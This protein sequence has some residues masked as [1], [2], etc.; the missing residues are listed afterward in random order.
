MLKDCISDLSDG[1]GSIAID[2]ERASGYKYSARAYLLQVTRDQK[3]IYLID[4]ISIDDLKLWQRFNETFIETEWIIHASTQDLPCLKELGLFPKKLF[5]TELG[6]RL[7]GFPKVAL[8]SLV[9]TMLEFEL[10]KEHSAVDWS[11]RPLKE[12]WLTYAA[13]DVDLLVDLRNKIATELENQGKLE[14]A[15]AE[16]AQVLKDFETTKSARK[17]PWRRTSGMHKVKDRLTMYIISN[18]WQI[19]DQIAQQLD[20]APHRVLQDEAIVDI[21]MRRPKTSEEIAKIIG[22][23]TRLESP[24]FQK[25]LQALNNS[26]ASPESNWPPL[27]LAS[28]SIPPTKVWRQK[29]T[30]GY[31]RLMHARAKLLEISDAQKIPIENLFPPEALKQICWAEPPN[32][33]AALPNYVN[34]LAKKFKVRDWQIKLCESEL[35]FAL[36]QTEPPVLPPP[37]PETSTSPEIEGD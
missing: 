27:R 16:F 29:N 34:E 37:Q 15:E 9:E 33:I 22:R 26:L 24:P 6:A 23:R 19:R 30:A 12:E 36:T 13:L 4:P 11:F 14:L 7:C 35:C 32:Q 1:Q 21:A 28:T 18:L 20:L 8:G 3:N 5:D 25:W 31:A 10:A 17:D 2:A